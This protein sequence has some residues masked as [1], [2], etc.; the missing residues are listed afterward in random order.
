MEINNLEI[1]SFTDELEKG[2]QAAAA[3][4]IL[5]LIAK[6]IK[7]FKATKAMAAGTQAFYRKGGAGAALGYLAKFRS[8]LHF[9]ERGAFRAGKPLRIIGLQKG[10]PTL[11]RGI[12]TSIGT[13]AANIQS[14]T[15]GMRGKRALSG[16]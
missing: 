5:P 7:G 10:P 6:S 1:L 13:T 14:L 16:S 3:L 4:R 8:P 11:S 15:T 12:R 9:V 2:A